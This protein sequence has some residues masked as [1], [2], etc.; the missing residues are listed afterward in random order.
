MGKE[1]GLITSILKVLGST[2]LKELSTKAS[3]QGTLVGELSKDLRETIDPK[4]KI[5]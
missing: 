2:V 1:S 4:D 3:L 5:K